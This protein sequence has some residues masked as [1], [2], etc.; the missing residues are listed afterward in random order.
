MYDSSS[1]YQKADSKFK[2]IA[3]KCNEKYETLK[4]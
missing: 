4:I 1:N 2:G 3:E